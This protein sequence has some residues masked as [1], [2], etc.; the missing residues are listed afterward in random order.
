MPF[1]ETVPVGRAEGEARAMYERVQAGR[2]YV[3]NYAK[4]FGERPQV[5][6]AWGA[7]N[8]RISGHMEARRYELVTLAAARALRS[9]YCALAH[10]S[11]L[12]RDQ[13]VPPA[14][15]AAVAAGESLAGMPGVSAADAAAMRFAEQ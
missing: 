15:V 7:L 5:M 12:L 14:A 1:I 8:G 13:L 10:G 3:P 9:S 6:A 4:V 11:V 2:G